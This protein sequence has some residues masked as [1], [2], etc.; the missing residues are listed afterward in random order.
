MKKTHLAIARGFASHA[1]DHRVKTAAQV[2]DAARRWLD[3]ND[4]IKLCN[5]FKKKQKKH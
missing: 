4:L 3:D 2:K 5:L 1:D